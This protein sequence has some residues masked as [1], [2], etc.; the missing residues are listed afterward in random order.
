MTLCLTPLSCFSRASLLQNFALRNGMPLDSCPPGVL[1]GAYP[2]AISKASLSSAGTQKAKS[3]KK[4]RSRSKT[5][6]VIFR[7][8]Q[9]MTASTPASSAST[10]VPSPEYH[11]SNSPTPQVQPKPWPSPPAPPSS[12][13][14]TRTSLPRS[15]A[16]SASGSS[17]NS[18]STCP[19]P[20]CLCSASSLMGQLN[21]STVYAAP[22]PQNIPA[23]PMHYSEIVAATP[24]ASRFDD[25]GEGFIYS[26]VP[27]AEA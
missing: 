23:G 11:Q 1:G 16:G 7:G 2:N 25:S 9:G 18:G 13:S 27:Q 14:R 20:L 15:R 19:D 22:P 21:A 5:M 17:S 4:S 26:L 8:G 3:R 12:I 10:T 24:A 6:P